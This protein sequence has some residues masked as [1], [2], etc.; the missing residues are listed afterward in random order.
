MISACAAATAVANT[1]EHKGRLDSLPLVKP[2]RASPV[3]ALVNDVN[4][5]ISRPKSG[6]G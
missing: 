4:V 1:Y 6:R 3:R 5:R 2:D